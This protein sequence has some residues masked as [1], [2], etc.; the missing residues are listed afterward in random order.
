MIGTFFFLVYN[1]WRN[2]LIMR[3]RRIK[4]PKYAVGAV[5]GALW[6]YFYFFRFI[7]FGAGQGTGAPAINPGN[8]LNWEMGGA[9]IL[10]AV[11]LLSWIIPHERGALVFSEAE[12]AF[13]FPAPIARRTLIHFKLLRSQLGI[14]FTTLVFTLLFRRNMTG[15]PAWIRAL[16][17]WMVLSTMGLHFLS[18]SFIRTILLDRGISTWKRRTVVLGLVAVAATTVAIWIARTLPPPGNINRPSDIA[19]Y[20]NLAIN[21][22]PLPW[23]I[24]PF[25]LV[26]RPYF[27]QNA[28]QFAIAAAPALAILA[29]HYLWVVRCN[30]SFEE[31]SVEASRKIAERVA[32]YRANRGQGAVIPTKK[33]K[34]PFNLSPTGSPT[35]GFLWKNLIAAG[36]A[37]TLRFWIVCAL[38][39]L[40]IA[41]FSHVT[42]RH[43]DITTVIAF[44]S[45]I[46]LGM[47]FFIGP[48]LVRQD[49]RTD[50]PMGDVLKT[51]PLSG[52]QVALGE[53]LAPAAIL[54][55]VQWL[56]IIIAAAFPVQFEHPVAIPV[57]LAF[58]AGLAIIVAPLSVVSLVIPNAAVL[59]FPAWFQTGQNAP[60]GIEVTGQRVIFGLGQVLVLVLSMVAPALAFAAVYIPLDWFVTGWIAA[61]PVAAVPTAIVLGVE[62]FY[63]IHFLGRV[64]EKLDLSAESTS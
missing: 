9:M 7:I 3:F 5:V 13:L 51:Y 28:A 15:S 33:M 52:R 35:M 22:G 18:A 56:L 21:S 54:T 62:A 47:S 57:R 30:V 50:L 32:A 27:A 37:Y 19:S 11:L 29:L 23:L 34:A 64:F 49:F 6:L 48:Q 44:F 40:M 16:G 24:Y 26:V 59:L 10:G 25:R 43:Q 55:G 45:L 17:W 20:F 1:S 61:I 41:L 42:T 58:A 12:V 39:V 53:L 8:A 60:Q 38:M 2:R 31:A 46:L 4:Q 14:L 63:G 36:Q